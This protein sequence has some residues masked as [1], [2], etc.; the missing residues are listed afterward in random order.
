MGTNLWIGGYAGG[1]LRTAIGDYRNSGVDFWPGYIDIFTG[2]TD[3]TIAK[4]YNKVWKVNRYDIED[5]KYNFLMG[6]VQN[7]SYTIPNSIL[8]WP[9]ND[10]NNSAIPLAPFYDYD[11]DFYYNPHNGDYPL[12]KGDQMIWW[13]FNDALSAH[14]ISGSAQNMNIEVRASAYAY[15]CPTVADS[16][17]V[18]NY[19]TFYN[20]QIINKSSNAF[21]SVRIGIRGEVDLGNP[22]DD[23]LGCDV[24]RNLAYVYNGDNYDED[25]G[26]ILGYGSNMP[27]FA[28][29][30]LRGP[31]ADYGNGK[32]DDRDGCTDCTWYTDANG[33]PMPGSFFYDEYT[34]P[35]HTCMETYVSYNNDA[36]ARTGNPTSASK[37]YN[38][39]TAHWLDNNINTD[40]IT[41]GNKGTDNVSTGGIPCTYMYPG[42]SDPYGYGLGGSP[43]NPIASPIWYS[44]TENNVAGNPPGDRRLLTSFGTFSLAYGET[45]NIDFA[46]VFTQ[47]NSDNNFAAIPAGLVDND[48]V[49]KWFILNNAPSC[50][51]LSTI[52]LK[53]NGK[54]INMAVFPNP[55]STNLTIDAGGNNTITG[56]KVYNIL[57]SLVMEN[58]SI[59]QSKTSI[60]INTLQPA[61]YLLEVSSNN[62][63]YFTRFI[64]E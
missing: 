8:T 44:W 40:P 15:F 58:K 3:S 37:Y 1:Q 14:G 27:M 21:D 63:T 41:Y 7:G 53:Q 22:N 50:I 12:I 47:T 4:Y 38:L 10:L 56:I 46:C 61:V 24:G 54:D 28:Y 49:R 30:M 39:L 16:D 62:G 48:K 2:T 32:D 64:K 9:G 11:G 26:T 29:N 20:Y 31:I 45:T 34:V 55:A 59:N 25:N 33:N 6:N 36:N 35:E 17:K 60:T 51:D 5:F 43:S 19:T 18:I 23:Y 13:V 57:G 52:G 42:D